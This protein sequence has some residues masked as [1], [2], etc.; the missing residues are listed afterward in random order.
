MCAEQ[1]TPA[2]MPS[3]RMMPNPY[4]YPS[5]VSCMDTTADLT[6][7]YPMPMGGGE[8]GPS[9]FGGCMPFCGGMYGMGMYGM[10]PGSEYLRMDTRTAMD[11]Q[12]GLRFAQLDNGVELA[13]RTQDANYQASIHNKMVAEKAAVLQG[14]I[15]ENNQDQIATAYENLKEAVRTKL[16]Y[17]S[18][19][20]AEA[21]TEHKIE[22]E[23][24]TL[25]AE[26][27]KA[28]IPDDLRK[29]G[30]SP[31]MSGFKKALGGIGWLFMDKK[32][33][34]ENIA[35]V[36]GTKIP[37]SEK[38]K[39]IAGGIMSLALTF[40]G[41]LLLH[42]GYKAYKNPTTLKVVTGAA[43]SLNHDAE[44][45]KLRPLAEKYKKAAMEEIYIGD[46]VE[47]LHELCKDGKLLSQD[48]AGDACKAYK[49]I[50]DKIAMHETAKDASALKK[51]GITI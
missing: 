18:G 36:E 31:F 32:S 29:Y 15:K 45:A 35:E 39:E 47:Y 3:Y 1:V 22:A 7:S 49:A 13:R 5:L 10:G 8:F 26:A 42:K 25:Y 27:L 14:L 51:A 21:P 20:G 33:S 48:G 46:D 2:V 41:A 50:F 17:E 44:L 24:K 43:G 16:V 28:N 30:D 38:A 9:V 40:V 6:G 12:N 34:I 4:S 37:K 11:Y 23:T 19:S